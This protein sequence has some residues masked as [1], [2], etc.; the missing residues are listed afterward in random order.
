MLASKVNLNPSVF[1]VWNVD[2]CWHLFHS[3]RWIHASSNDVGNANEYNT[4][5]A[6]FSFKIVFADFDF[7]LAFIVCDFAP[8]QRIHS[9]SEA[10]VRRLHINICK[11][12]KVSSMQI[13]KSQTENHLQN[14]YAIC[15]IDLLYQDL[16]LFFIQNIHSSKILVV[17][18]I[19]TPIFL[20]KFSFFRKTLKQLYDLDKKT[21]EL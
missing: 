4:E 10:Q 8:K 18:S 11:W 17:I 20:L 7:N 16:K 9:L 14:V 5:M 2:D 13:P 19:G 15:Y 1:G 21:F 3:N 6:K 12:W